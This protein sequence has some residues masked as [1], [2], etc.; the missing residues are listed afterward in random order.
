MEV[1]GKFQNK[2]GAYPHDDIIDK[3]EFGSKIFSKSKKGYLHV[4]RPNTFL[5]THSLAQRTQILFTPD[6]S[7]VLLR[8]KLKPGFKV[9]ES[10][11]GSG[12]LSV[13]LC[14]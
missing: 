4:L 2:H 11:T 12:S 7:M 3:I 8:L 9:V 6:I 14:R 10:G 1:G 5:Y 13:S